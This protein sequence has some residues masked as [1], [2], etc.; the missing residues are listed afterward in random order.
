[1]TSIALQSLDVDVAEEFGCFETSDQPLEAERRPLC[2]HE[3]CDWHNVP[4]VVNSPSLFACG[5][6]G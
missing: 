4:L 3:T 1:M 6:A 2:R 5:R